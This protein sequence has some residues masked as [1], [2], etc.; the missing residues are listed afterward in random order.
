MSSWKM[1]WSQ[2]VLS[3]VGYSQTKGVF[4]MYSTY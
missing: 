2:D 1:Y 4:I 3:P